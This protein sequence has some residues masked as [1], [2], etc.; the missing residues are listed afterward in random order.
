MHLTLDN[1]KELDILAGF[2]INPEDFHNHHWEIIPYTVKA[3]NAYI[4]RMHN[5]K[6]AELPEH[7][8]VAI[9]MSNGDMMI[10][11]PSND[12]FHRTSQI[13]IRSNK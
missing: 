4:E 8:C 6:G 3:L 5:Y 1:A 11:N 9:I 12:P 10:H 2:C 13:V 7:T